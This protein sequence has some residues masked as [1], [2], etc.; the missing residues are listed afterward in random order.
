VIRFWNT[1]VFESLDDVAD[2]IAYE[3]GLFDGHAPL[4]SPLPCGERGQSS[5]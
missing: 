2:T 3:L 1:D 5:A 4:P